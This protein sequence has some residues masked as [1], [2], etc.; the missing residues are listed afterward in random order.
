MCT[1]W[2]PASSTRHVGEA[3]ERLLHRDLRFE[4]RQRSA[5]A[6]VRAVPEREVAVDLPAHVEAI[7]IGKV[8]LVAIGGAIQQDELRAPRNGGAVDLDVAVT[9]RVFTGEGAS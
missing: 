4:P 2:S 7:G 9:Q 1:H 6:E 3:G 8:A 5:D